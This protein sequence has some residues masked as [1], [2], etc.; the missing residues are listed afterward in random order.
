[1]PV[2]PRY[3]IKVRVASDMILWLMTHGSWLMNIRRNSM[4]HAL[5]LSYNSPGKDSAMGTRDQQKLI[6]KLARI[7]KMDG[8]SGLRVAVNEAT[9]RT[10]SLPAIASRLS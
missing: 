6:V 3:L 4:T 5:L 2:R 10:A 9:L 1:M 8:D 7:G